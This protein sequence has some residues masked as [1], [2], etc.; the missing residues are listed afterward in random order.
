[1]RPH[2]AL[3]LAAAAAA[4]APLTYAFRGQPPRR[5]ASSAPGAASEARDYNSKILVVD[6]TK[7]YTMDDMLRH[8]WLNPDGMNPPDNFMPARPPTV[9]NPDPVAVEQLVKFGYSRDSSAFSEPHA[10]REWGAGGGR[11]GRR[12]RGARPRE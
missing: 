11:R 6:A 3:V 1:M 5:A 2:T 4:A 12:R 9:D 7:R 8:P 10:P